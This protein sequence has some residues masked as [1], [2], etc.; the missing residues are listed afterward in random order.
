MSGALRRS[1]L[2]A[3]SAAVLLVVPTAA[4]GVPRNDYL[5]VLDRRAGPYRYLES[6]ERGRPGAY[7]SALAAFGKPT[8]ARASANFCRVTWAAS[9]ITIRFASRPRPCV[10]SNLRAAAWYGM[11]LHGRRWHNR[12]GVRVGDRV[13]EVRR[14]YPNARFERPLGKPWLVLARRRVDEFDFIRLAVAVSRDRRVA[15]IEIPATYVY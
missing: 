5:L 9:E 6:F 7:V 4:S 11:S 2:L 10:R 12:K 1:V 8:R 13:A 15:S 14:L 3:T